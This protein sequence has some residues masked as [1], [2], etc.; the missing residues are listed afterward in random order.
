MGQGCV[1]FLL[2]IVFPSIKPEFPQYT[3]CINWIKM[4]PP[5]SLWIIAIMKTNLANIMAALSMV[6][7]LGSMSSRAAASQPVEA[8]AIRAAA[9]S[10][11]T[12]SDHEVVAK[13]YE[14]AA[15]ELQAK[16]AEKM[17]LLERYENKSYLYGRQAQDLTSHTH[18]LIRNYEKTVRKNMQ[19][20][21]MHRQ[22]AAKLSENH[23]STGA[24]MPNALSG[25]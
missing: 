20:A 11:T 2:L 3:D 16:L 24:R 8:A 5:Y 12:Q 17:E 22:I 9:E 15:T 10:A 23:A 21:A 19:A 13:Q 7:L 14:D 6:G 1:Q 25:L 4:K 18:A